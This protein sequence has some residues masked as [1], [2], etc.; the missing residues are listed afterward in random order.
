MTLKTI[1]D[2][3]LPRNNNLNRRQSDFSQELS[4]DSLIKAMTNPNKV[5]TNLIGDLPQKQRDI[6]IKRFGLKNGKRTTLEAIGNEY[7]ITRERVRQIEEDALTRLRKPQVISQLAGYFDAISKHLT[8]HGHI[9][10]EEHLLENDYK[11]IFT[12]C[13]TSGHPRAIVHFLLTL[14]KPFD[15]IPETNDLHGFWT[16]NKAIVPEIKE[17]MADLHKKLE[18]HGKTINKETL[19][20]FVNSSVKEKGVAAT[21]KA[22]ISYINISKKIDSNVFGEYGMANWTEIKPRGMKDKAYLILKRLQKPVHFT[23]VAKEI[24]KAGLVKNRKG[25]LAKAHP[26]TVHN[27]LIKDKRFVLVGRGTYALADWGFVP[28]T[29][30]DVITQTIE[31]AKKPLA[32][33]EILS[34]VLAQRQVKENTILL[35]LQ[36]KKLFRKVDGERYTL[37]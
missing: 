37:A 24:E 14:G 31:T 30:K 8:N 27:E 10:N 5:I 2:T 12:D 11:E 26:Q 1:Y 29:I 18:K 4:P 3:L 22:L 35:N 36:N 34:A 16:T 28:G 33:E 9:K 17:I 13:E 23:Q 20:D 7:G 21:E 32:K 25:G 6:V 19:L 15:K